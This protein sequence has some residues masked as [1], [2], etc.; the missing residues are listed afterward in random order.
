MNTVERLLYAI[1]LVVLLSHSGC[2]CVPKIFLRVRLTSTSTGH[3]FWFEKK[4]QEKDIFKD[5]KPDLSPVASDPANVIIVCFP[6]NADVPTL[7]AVA[8]SLSIKQQRGCG[9]KIDIAE[10]PGDYEHDK[11][12]LSLGAPA[13]G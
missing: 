7:G 8:D 11:F 6:A 2:S 4:E 13:I 5:L 3:D 12:L 10:P 9:Q 1:L